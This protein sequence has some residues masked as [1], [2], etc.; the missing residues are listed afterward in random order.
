[1]TD[2]NGPVSFPVVSTWH[3][4]TGIALAV[5]RPGEQTAAVAVLPI[6][7]ALTQFVPAVLAAINGYAR[8]RD[9]IDDINGAFD[10]ALGA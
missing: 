2:T 4:D 9:M 6:D 5:A 3:T 10:G 1:M 7:V 8:H